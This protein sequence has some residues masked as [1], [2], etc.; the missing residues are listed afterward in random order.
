M[1]SP[2]ASS[3]THLLTNNPVDQIGRECNLAT[4]LI[5]SP[6]LQTVFVSSTCPAQVSLLVWDRFRIP[7]AITCPRLLPSVTDPQSEVASSSMAAATPFRVIFVARS[8]IWLPRWFLEEVEK[9]RFLRNANK[10]FIQ[11][12]TSQQKVPG[13]SMS[14]YWG[15]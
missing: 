3:S 9:V 2:L 15:F 12:I 14:H 6:P 10:S 13:V 1:F 4:T 11:C 5:P 8:S 7:R